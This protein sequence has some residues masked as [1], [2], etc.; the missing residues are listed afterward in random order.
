M[1]A[2]L[3]LSIVTMLIMLVL[4]GFWIVASALTDPPEDV[5]GGSGRM[6]PR[7]FGPGLLGRIRG[8]LNRKPPRLYYQRDH[9]GR[10]RKIRRW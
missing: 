8:W 7:R 5:I 2:V 3:L 1:A 4:G 6:R 10:F 9:L